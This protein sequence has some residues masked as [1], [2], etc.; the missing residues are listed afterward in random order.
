M[1]ANGT[2][3]GLWPFVRMAMVTQVILWSIPVER[4]SRIARRSISALVLE[5]LARI[6]NEHGVD[7]LVRHAALPERGQHVVVDVLVVPVGERRGDHR[8]GQ[9]VVE[10]MGR[11]STILSA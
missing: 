6:L 1:S 5:D 3:G 2:S 8:F 9:R 10:A 4:T 7:L 11:A